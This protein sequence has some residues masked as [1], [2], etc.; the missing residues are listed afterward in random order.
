MSEGP[1]FQLHSS[2]RSQLPVIGSYYT[3]YHSLGISDSF[4]K[5]F[6][7]IFPSI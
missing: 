7:S 3:L 2:T 6:V 1:D 4:R 5:I